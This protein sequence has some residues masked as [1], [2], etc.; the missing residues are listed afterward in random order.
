MK[1]DDNTLY[2]PTARNLDELFQVLLARGSL[3]CPRSLRT[4][5]RNPSTFEHLS[6]NGYGLGPAKGAPATW[7]HGH[8]QQGLHIPLPTAL[9]RELSQTEKRKQHHIHRHPVAQPQVAS[10][11]TACNG[12]PAREYATCRLGLKEPEEQN[13]SSFQASASFLS[14]L[15]IPTRAGCHGRNAPCIQLLSCH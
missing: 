8:H 15:L 14:L 13:N 1:L 2:W 4:P 5:T 6:K 11:H 10:L 3:P 9:E 7:K 12:L